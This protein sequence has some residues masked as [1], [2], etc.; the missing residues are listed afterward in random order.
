M[1]I[2]AQYATDA[3]LENN[4][5]WQEL[6]DAK[7]LVART[8]NRKY[9]QALSA[10]VEK[11]QKLLDAKG[12]AADTLSDKIM[13]DVLASTI[14]LGWEGVSFKGQ[15]LDYSVDNAKTLLAIRDFRR[16]IV[17]LADSIDGYRAKLEEEQVKN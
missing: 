13:V 11:N 17:K 8:G 5:T 16:E 6:G 15:P 3:S 4:G 7:F 2:F 12:E 9:V 10:A 14:L 1:D